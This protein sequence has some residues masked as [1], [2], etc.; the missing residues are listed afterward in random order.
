MAAAL[1]ALVL[2]LQTVA[3]VRRADREPHPDETEYLHAAWLMS[4]GGQLYTSFFEHH[5]PF[6][7]AVLRAIA[8]DDVP[9]YFVRARL[10]AGVFALI[11]LG[12]FAALVWRVRPEAAPLALALLFV[13]LPMWINGLA[14]ARAEPFALAFFWCG[15]AL[16]FLPRGDERL[17]AIA[18]GAGVAFLVIAALWIPK[19][20]FSS[21]VVAAFWLVRTPRRVLSAAVAA[22]VALPAIL[23]LRLY[24]T[25]EQLWFFVVV[26][27]RANYPWLGRHQEGWDFGGDALFFAP[28]LLRPVV[29]IPALAIVAAAL[30]RKQLRDAPPVV[31][32]LLLLAASA[33]ELRF[34]F[35]YPVLWS[36]YFLMYAFAAAALVALAPFLLPWRMVANA[37]AVALAVVVTAYV[38]AVAPFDSGGDEGPYWSSQR[39]LARA[40][41]NG[42]TVWLS[43]KRHP[44]AVHDATYYWFGFFNVVPSLQRT[45]AGARL[46]PPR[47]APFCAMLAGAKMNLRFVSEPRLLIESAEETRCFQQLL[48]TQRI[49]R[50][51]V[52][53][54]YEV[55]E[56][57]PHA[58]Q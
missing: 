41:R 46:L 36:Y 10:L 9:P 14:A 52:A 39:Y 55:L 13:S 17:A 34:V 4:H 6:L 44:V 8:S 30:F 7:F 15:A 12:A 58:A 11:A 1:V 24:A 5:P 49:R 50:S 20:P 29:V 26:F 2:A 27:N 54:V 25:F 3:I 19:W 22:L 51:R 47:P 40:L 23:A 43:P 56:E 33:L 18:G 31:F 38:I 45:P 37:L 21:A 42:G 16:V 53:T 48:A 32:F 35:P 28:L 57:K